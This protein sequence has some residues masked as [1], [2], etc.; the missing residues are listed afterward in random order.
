MEENK[1]SFA[2]EQVP[3]REPTELEKVQ[4]RIANYQIGIKPQS[5]QA[6][7]TLLELHLKSGLIKLEELEVVV[8]VRDEVQKGLASY[9]SSVEHAQRQLV[10]LQ[11]ADRLAKEAAIE[12]EKAQLT[13]K[14]REQRKQRKDAELKVAQL[15][16]ILASHGVNVDLNNDGVI[17]V[18]AGDLN[19]DGFVELTKEEAA[20]LAA[21]HGVTIP[22]TTIQKGTIDETPKKTSKAFQMARLLNPEEPVEQSEPSVAEVQPITEDEV[23]AEKIEETKV[24][25]SEWEEQSETEVEDE[26]MVFGNESTEEDGF[27][28]PVEDETITIELPVPEDAKGIEAFLEEVETVQQEAEIDDIDEEQFNQS[29]EEP[30]GTVESDREVDEA[31]EGWDANGSPTTEEPHT[32]VSRRERV[33][34]DPLEASQRSDE[35]RV[36]EEDTKTEPTYAKPSAVPITST[37]MPRQTLK[38]G[39]SVEAEVK[40][41]KINT[42]D[43]EEEMLEAVQQKIDTAKEQEE[44]FEELVI[45]SADELRGMTKKKIK[46]TAEGLN[47]EVTTSDTKEDMIESIAEQTESL[48]QSLQESD[49]FV[50]ATETVKDEDENVDRR[51]GGYF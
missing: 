51:D 37:N 12:S 24:A 46:E 1:T 29:F 45:P 16:A 2:S 41:Q 47:F 5:A 8:A 39:D 28:L 34:L 21:E 43:S 44:E 10:E 30:V 7:N 3:P 36:A 25:I 35:L 31:L 15:E 38:S 32:E 33:L 11:E 19:A 49:E 42:Y 6:V 14:I 50:S 27:D 22:K 4:Q 48:I 18:K 23:L 26:E 13:D 40:E 9:N 20:T 17:G